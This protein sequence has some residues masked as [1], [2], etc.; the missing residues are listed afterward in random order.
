MLRDALQI[1]G[2]LHLTK[3]DSEL[4]LE[5]AEDALGVFQRLQERTSS[6]GRTRGALRR[7]QGSTSSS[8]RSA[9]LQWRV[10]LQSDSKQQAS[11][12]RI[13]EKRAQELY[14][15]AVKA[16][17]AAVDA[18]RAC[19]E[20]RSLAGSLHLLGLTLGASRVEAACKEALQHAL[21]ASRLSH[22]CG[23]C[24]LEAQAL[25]AQADLRLLL[26]EQPSLLGAP[27]SLEPLGHLA[28]GAGQAAEGGAG[29]IGAHLG[30]MKIS[31]A[32]A[33]AAAL[34]GGL[35]EPP[36]ASQATADPPA[37]E[38]SAEMLGVVAR[39][40]KSAIGFPDEIDQEGGR[41]PHGRRHGQSLGSVLPQWRPAEDLGLKLPS[42]LVLDHPTLREVAAQLQELGGGGA[43]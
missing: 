30:G 2:N 4:A 8:G 20:K 7:R 16:A 33:G 32:P 13:A 24:N 12:M 9:D 26:G 35:D 1:V 36:Q 34:L 21:A 43:G 37:A 41:R 14:S 10:K 40:A 17:R 5:V 25:L 18:A 3:G 27:S 22:E 11:R 15:V 23:D 28:G 31:H 38:A 6:G 29:E 19:G 42:T 39:L